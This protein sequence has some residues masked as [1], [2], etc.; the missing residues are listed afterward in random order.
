MPVRTLTPKLDPDFQKCFSAL[1]PLEGG[2]VDDPE[3]P[4]GPTNYGVTQK[5]YDA[6]QNL[7]N[8]PLKPVMAISMDEVQ[9][10]YYDQ[11]W[12]SVRA[13]ALPPG[14]DFAVFD[15][16]VHSGPA[17]AAKIL[18]GIVGQTQDGSLGTQTLGAVRTYLQNS[19][20]T[21]KG[22]I[23][24]YYRQREKYLHSLAKWST[25]SR[26]WTAR[27]VSSRAI[28]ISMLYPDT[29]I[30]ESQL[31]QEHINRITVK[32]KGNPLPRAKGSISIFNKKNISV[33]SILT[34]VETFQMA[35]IMPPSGA[36][37][38]VTPVVC[39][40]AILLIVYMAHPGADD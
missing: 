37:H 29:G 13:N 6:Y 30:S 38:Y 21:V 2:Y 18:Q 15:C 33:A 9:G 20:A 5:T 10:I 22:L 11:Y 19:K 1:L 14:L 28:A 25:Y 27:I 35:D 34:A 32:P 39:I 23:E 4:G 8:Q 12:M 16:A 36:L 40:I 31:V 17:R 7:L 3:D 24:K 26:G